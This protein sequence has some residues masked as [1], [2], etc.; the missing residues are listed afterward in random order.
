MPKLTIDDYEIEVP[1]G[2]KVIDAADMLGIV[3]PR[4]CYHEAL[5]AVG[6]C[7]LCAVKF[8]H[9]PFRGVQM[10][11]M[12]DAQDG[13]V[14]STT[15][16]EAVA[17]RKRIIE[18]LM[19]NHPHDCPV[20]DE[21]GQCLL[22]DETVSSGHA[23]R[24]YPGYKRTYRNQDLGVFIH[25]E[26]NRCI[27]CYRCSRFYQD[28]GGYRDLGAMQIGSRV[29]FGRF[30]E[31]QLES[32][33]SGNLVDICPVGVY[34]DKTARYKVRRWDLERS[35][36]L[37]IHCSLGCNTIA[38]ARYRATMRIEARHH[39]L[40]N[41][42]FICD[43]G[44]FG[45]AYDNGGEGSKAQRPRQTRIGG[46]E[47][48]WDAAAQSAAERLSRISK[49]AGPTA[50]AALGS[51]RSSLEALALL[52][53]ISR[54]E[55][56]AEPAFFLDP[57]TLRKV[58]SAVSRL[59]ERI[60]VSLHEIEDADFILA[61]G[62]DPVN[63]APMLAL[64]M[65]QAWRK[66][67][68][69]TV[70]DPRPVALPMQFEH[71]PVAPGL[72]EECIEALTRKALTRE[73][74]SAPSNSSTI[75]P[76]LRDSISALSDK[77]RAARNPVIICGT[78]VVRETTPVAAANHA[79]SLLAG[80]GKAGLFY[81]F[82]GANAFAASLLSSPAG[83][84]FLDTLEDIE[85][86][87]IKALIVVESDPLRC[88]GDKER[89]ERALDKLDFLL[90]LDYLPSETARRSHVFLPT[91][92]IFETGSS[93]INQEGRL[94]FAEP[95]H[96]PG[97][98][99]YGAH[100]PKAFKDSVPGG[101]PK[102]AWMALS[103]VAHAIT[104]P[105]KIFSTELR[106]L[107]RRSNE[108]IERTELF[109][110]GKEWPTAAVWSAVTEEIPILSHLSP[111][112]YPFDN[113]R[114]IPEKAGERL[115]LEERAQEEKILIEGDFEL[116]LTDRLFGSEE[117]TAYSDVIQSLAKEPCLYI[118]A[119]DALKA[120]ISHGDKV[121]LRLDR[122]A[123][124]LTAMVTERMA[125]ATLVLPRLW[126]LEWQKMESTPFIVHR[127]AVERIISQG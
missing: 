10:S 103:E 59:D 2:T 123:L 92:T 15:D 55:G 72:I 8:I 102:A 100:P 69:V 7:R 111:A 61:A 90:A 107:E 5:G 35:P 4:F 74:E 66:G 119:K 33:F 28:Y 30:K 56:W 115:E 48:S 113:I 14:V 44:R 97:I 77:L 64:S 94:Q 41:G 78:D 46:E 32:P 1:L 11:C 83:P 70:I 96:M 84:S 31:G 26:M 93:F 76:A 109:I 52:K 27:H 110:P 71:L 25:H 91:T 65:R 87:V 43:R 86:G 9:G 98:P 51:P 19:I 120:G 117:L 126:G 50:I 13:M 17:F 54:L 57:A 34:T 12:I 40:V 39:K 73:E 79:F 112:E 122:G 37:C 63:E 75:D 29:Y 23:I 108:P 116:I 99:L 38:N 42:H 101:E 36:S 95:V 18:L 104:E 22:Q 24:R 20:C 88:F 21:G 85:K 6:A 89:L 81:L 67:A 58:R 127:G 3:I 114:V 124:E 118:H 16:E 82:P 53:R 80:K 68:V 106:S 125:P 121:R 60:A 105:G 49:A 62:V 45:F 47:S